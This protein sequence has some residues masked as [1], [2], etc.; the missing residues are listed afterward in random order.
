LG[1]P[2]LILG[3]VMKQGGNRLV[4]VSVVLQRDRGNSQ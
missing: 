1:K 4:L 3:G 2:V